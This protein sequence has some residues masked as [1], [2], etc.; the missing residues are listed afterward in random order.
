MHRPYN[1]L[2]HGTVNFTK[3]FAF[4]LFSYINLQTLAAVYCI[5]QLKK[6]IAKAHPL[7]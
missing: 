3:L 5:N 4:N 6:L 1:W 2:A 7:L